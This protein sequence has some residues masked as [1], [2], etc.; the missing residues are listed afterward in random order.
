MYI[1]G[2]IRLPFLHNNRNKL[3]HIYNII[4]ILF[5]YISILTYLCVVK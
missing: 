5:A 2:D 1:K 4:L 3:W